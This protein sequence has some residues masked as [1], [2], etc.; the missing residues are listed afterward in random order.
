MGSTS[1]CHEF[2]INKLLLMAASCLAHDALQV[3]AISSVYKMAMQTFRRSEEE[4]KN[5][6]SHDSH[7]C[8]NSRASLVC[9][10][11]IAVYWQM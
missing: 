1:K 10:H 6:D 5:V 2:A 3:S 8:K 9:V 7:A 11:K 4:A